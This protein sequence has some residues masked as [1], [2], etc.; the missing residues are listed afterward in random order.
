[1]KELIKFIENEY[2]ILQNELKE[3]ERDLST[4]ERAYTRGQIKSLQDVMNFIIHLLK[5]NEGKRIMITLTA[6]QLIV[7]KAILTQ[8]KEGKIKLAAGT[9]G[10]LEDALDLPSVSGVRA[11]I[12]EN[13]I[14]QYG[15]QQ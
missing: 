14:E 7:C 2:K 13:L 12:I 9:D 3:R 1:M 5:T 8:F 4:W 6:D 15:G 10:I 11:F